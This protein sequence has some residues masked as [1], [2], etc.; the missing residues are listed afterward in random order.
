MFDGLNKF[1]LGVKYAIIGLIGGII[2]A[3]LMW[4]FGRESDL[5]T[6]IVF[7]LAGAVGGYV[8][9]RIRQ[10]SGKED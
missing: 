1:G 6:Y 2:G 8:G 9:G 10:K 4:F 3:G 7:P 5:N